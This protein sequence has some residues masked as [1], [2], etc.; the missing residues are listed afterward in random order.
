MEDQIRE[1]GREKSVKKNMGP[2]EDEEWKEN[3]GG[4][5]RKG[6]TKENRHEQW[7]KFLMQD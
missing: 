7:N 1:T 5:K 6:K 3:L 4:K 2:K